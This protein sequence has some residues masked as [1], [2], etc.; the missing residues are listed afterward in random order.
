M[1]DSSSSRLRFSQAF[2]CISR[3]IPRKSSGKSFST[4]PEELPLRKFSLAQIKAATSNFDKGLL[5]GT[6]NFGSVYKGMIDEGSTTVAI[7]RMKLG[8]SLFRTEVILLCQVNHVNVESIIGFCDEKG[9]TIL[10]YEYLCNGSLYKCLYANGVN[11]NP[12]PWEKRLEICIGAARGLHYLHTGAKYV[13]MHR[14]VTSHTVLLDHDLVPKLSGFFVSKLGPL[15]MSKD[16]IK[17]EVPVVGAYGY[18][19]PEY[20]RTKYLSEKS[21]VYSF[22]VVLLEVICDQTKF[23]LMTDGVT[24]LAERA[25]LCFRNG[26]LHQNIDP[27]L[28]GRI[29]PECFDKFVEIAMHCISDTGDERPSMGEVE[30]ALELALELQKKSNSEM[31]SI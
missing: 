26:T 29:T 10:V 4:L 13:V 3:R 12:L 19:D 23:S 21:D 11:G 15:S 22:G 14:Y 17:K 1:T 2:G 30:V 7:R 18:L 8:L 28:Q 6:S 16:L 31:T 20:Q 24:Y 9:E 27:Y 5:I 25:T